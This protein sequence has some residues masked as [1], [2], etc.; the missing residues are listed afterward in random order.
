MKKPSPI[1]QHKDKDL[2]LI[3]EKLLKVIESEP[4]TATEVKALVEAGK[5]LARMHHALQIDKAVQKISENKNKAFDA[6][7]PKISPELQ[8]RIEELKPRNEVD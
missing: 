5:L 2:K 1:D 6:T 4:A 3:R 7:P 8:A